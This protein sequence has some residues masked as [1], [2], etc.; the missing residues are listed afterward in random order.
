MNIRQLLPQLAALL[1]LPALSLDETD[2]CG[3]VLEGVQVDLHFVE[4][5]QAL[6]LC[7]EVGPLDAQQRPEAMRQ[8]LQRNLSREGIGKAH[9]ALDDSGDAV[10]LCQ[11]LG[12]QDRTAQSVVEHVTAMVAACRASRESFQQHGLAHA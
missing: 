11:T 12:M 9:F 2:T 1:G 3:I 7:G 6:C 5:A 10:F 4:D 8:L